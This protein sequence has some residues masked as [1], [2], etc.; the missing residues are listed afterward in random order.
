MLQAGVL[1]SSHGAGES[2]IQASII[3]T[4]G[5]KS[6]FEHMELKEWLRGR[7]KSYHWYAV[8]VCRDRDTLSG[9]ILKG[10]RVRF[11]SRLHLIRTGYLS[12]L[13]TD[14]PKTEKVDWVV[15]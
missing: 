5:Q 15:V 9:I 4:Q 2:S 10:L 8:A 14:F 13:E 6:S 11:S 7:S 1:G 3:F 12:T